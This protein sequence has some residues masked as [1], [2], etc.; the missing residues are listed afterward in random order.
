M[1]L[2]KAGVI[3]NS[4]PKF[5]PGRTVVGFAFG[6]RALYEFLDHNRDCSSDPFL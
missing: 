5:I 4:R 3:N 2:V 6:S 1:A